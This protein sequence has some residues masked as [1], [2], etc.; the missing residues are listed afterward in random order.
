VARAPGRRWNIFQDKAT[1][2]LRRTH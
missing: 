1:E 2:V